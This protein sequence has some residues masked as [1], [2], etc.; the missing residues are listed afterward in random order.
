MYHLTEVDKC[1]L[2]AISSGALGGFIQAILQ[3]ILS[4]IKNSPTTFIQ[5]IKLYLSSCL[6]NSILMGL[7]IFF[8]AMFDTRA[9]IVN[10]A[11]FIVISGIIIFPLTTLSTE[12][13]ENFVF[14]KQDN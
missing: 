9:L 10:S 7:F 3:D 2:L 1:V 5:K 6:I 4:K 14:K 11:Q 8:G 13:L 12:I